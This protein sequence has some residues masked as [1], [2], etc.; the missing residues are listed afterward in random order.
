M[1]STWNKGSRLGMPLL[2]AIAA[3]SSASIPPAA[4]PEPIKID[5]TMSDPP[6]YGVSPHLGG[7]GETIFTRI[8]IGDPY[9]TGLPYPIFLALLSMYPDILGASP[10]AFV[11][12]FGFTPRAADPQSTDRDAR[13]GLPIGMH[14]TDDP[15][16][17]V[18]FLVPQLRAL[19]FRDRPLAWWREANPR[20]RKPSNS[21]P[22]VRRRDQQ[23]REHA[24][25]RSR[26]HRPGR[27]RK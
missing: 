21:H 2:L 3:C 7:R 20:N 18:P 25:L 9:R 6:E 13:E 15:N 12:R 24:E 23:D 4:S 17:R 10:E 26:A 27:A 16:T 8:G 14:L 5:V 22:C 19:P 11:D 1:R